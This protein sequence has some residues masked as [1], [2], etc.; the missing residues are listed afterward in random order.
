[1]K[2]KNGIHLIDRIGLYKSFRNF[3]KKY[4][5][6]NDYIDAVFAAIA[7]APIVEGVPVV[8]CRD[9]I[10]RGIKFFCPMCHDEYTWDEDDGAD[11]FTV[12]NTTDDGFCHRGQSSV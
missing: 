8:R 4:P 6:P 3:A 7:R 9:C 11:Y 10:H 5:D 2:K 1:M 12:D